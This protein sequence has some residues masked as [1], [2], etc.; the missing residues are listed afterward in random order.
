MI[1]SL[2]H[3]IKQDSVSVS[4]QEIADTIKVS[5]ILPAAVGLSTGLAAGIGGTYYATRPDEDKIKEEK[6]KLENKALLYGLGGAV[7]GF[8]AGRAMSNIGRPLPYSP[9]P[10]SIHGFNQEDIKYVMGRG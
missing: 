5:F 2:V 3:R 7:T 6:R 4:S 1:D 9:D 8:G 10:G